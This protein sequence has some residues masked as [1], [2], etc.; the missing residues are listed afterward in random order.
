MREQEGRVCG[1][2][3]DWLGG[4]KVELKGQWSA[5]KEQKCRG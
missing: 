1:C 2:K 3:E 4:E 5:G